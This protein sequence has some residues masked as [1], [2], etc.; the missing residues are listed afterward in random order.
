[1]VFIGGILD[2]FVSILHDNGGIAFIALKCEG[3]GI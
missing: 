3:G 2:F 1:M